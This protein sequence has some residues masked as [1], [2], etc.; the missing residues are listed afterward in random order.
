MSNDKSYYFTDE[1][2]KAELSFRNASKD[3]FSG[4]ASYKLIDVFGKQIFA[5]EI[6]K[7]SVPANQTEKQTIEIQLPSD[8][9]GPFHVVFEVKSGNK[10]YSDVAYAGVIERGGKLNKRIGLEVYGRQNFRIAAEYLR[11]FRIGCIR[12]GAA[13]AGGPEVLE[14]AELMKKNGFDIMFGTGFTRG[15]SKDPVRW[16]AQMDAYEQGFAKYGKYIDIIESDNEANITG[17]TIEQNRQQIREL[18]DII[19]KYNLKCKLAGPTSCRT[20]MAWTA[21]ILSSPE[22][23]LLDIVT[24]HPYRTLPELPD[25]ADDVVTMRKVIDLYT[26]GI[27]HYASESGR[28]HPYMPE[29]AGFVSEYTITTAA[30]DMRNIIQGFS[31]GLKRYYHFTCYMASGGNS[32][33]VLYGNTP[34]NNG[35][36]RPNPALY[37]L[38]TISDRLEQAECVKRIR[39]GIDY[40]CPVFDHGSKRTVVIWKWNGNPGSLAFLPEDVK[41]FTAYNFFGAKI[42][43]DKLE[44]N[45]IPIYL[46]TTL[47]AAD[48]EKAIRR[49]TLISEGSS[50]IEFTPMILGEKRFAVEVLN[51]TGNELK[52][53][54]VSID[55][56]NA[57]SSA[58]KQT[59]A[60]IGPEAKARADFEL[61]QT[62]STKNCKL[63]V[64]V[65]E[66]KSKLKKTE[67]LN[68]R[69]LL[70]KK[71]EKPLVIDG[72]LSDWQKN[73]EVVKLDKRNA[74]KLANAAWGEN[75]DKV[76]AELRYAWDERF[77]YMAVTVYKPEFHFANDENTV[78]NA[79]KFDSVQVAYDTLRNA[80]TGTSDLGDDDFDYTFAECCG[81]PFVIRH[82][83]SSA[84][85]DS[86]TKAVGVIR[87]EVEF[88][89]KRYADRVVYEIALPTRSV[90]P[91]KLVPYSM[92]RAGFLVNINNGKERAGWLE[93]TP[94]IGVY[95][96]HPDQW[97]DLVLLP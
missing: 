47:S 73:V 34:A 90:S 54:S 7:I 28:E 72:D 13:S 82:R 22:G 35:M 70:V 25:Y 14:N 79:W 75:E 63:K 17:M 27:P 65:Q 78:A 93:L 41:Q 23:K 81:K 95:P 66:P 52:D 59:I 96:K 3:G 2:I 50:P 8:F 60:S 74:V 39:L 4:I 89:V 85:H 58:E 19:K 11:D 53:I 76:R 77:L 94:G 84:I 97:M 18:H 49:A 30:R 37:A 67:T 87:D 10:T 56:P 68:L 44:M 5:K 88:A 92:M 26:P 45:E 57:L 43:A 21:N 86:L 31:A 55:T 15:T 38:R 9:R 48:A 61:K 36:P 64:S 69:A 42:P 32:Y 33:N 51:R 12:I 40:R 24:E 62:I 91:F 29:N 71:V 80:K 46:D 16:K 1:K 83:A 6:G 20:S